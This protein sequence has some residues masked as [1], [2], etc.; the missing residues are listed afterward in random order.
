[1]FEPA[2][3]E[4]T[5]HAQAAQ[6]SVPTQTPTAT[7]TP[8]ESPPTPTATST[9]THTPF[10]TPT[11]RPTTTVTPTP[12]EK[13][14]S[15]PT[16]RPHPTT[17]LRYV[18]LIQG[19]TSKGVGN[20]ESP[21][22]ADHIIRWREAIQIELGIEANRVLA[23]SY[24]NQ[25]CN[26]EKYRLPMYTALDTCDGIRDAV[27]A[28]DELIEET[29]V[30]EDGQA[31]F[32][33]IGH[34]LGG[35]VAA[36]WVTRGARTLPYVDSVITLDAPLG[37]VPDAGLVGGFLFPRCLDESGL[38]HETTLSI[39]DADLGLE[40]YVRAVEIPQLTTDQA[41]FANLYCTEFYLYEGRACLGAPELDVPVTMGGSW[42][43]R[44][45]QGDL[46]NGQKLDHVTLIFH[47]GT[48]AEITDIFNFDYS[49]I[50]FES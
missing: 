8:T 26:G 14:T 4:P 46:D 42:R 27:A 37:E 38:W 22:Q 30:L 35:F 15:T 13:P 10:P 29:L 3:A 9:P 17:D 50:Q 19:L 48:L 21:S 34:S 32:H 49:Q 6:G 2:P 31:R 36:Y 18:V 5:P 45:I 43:T 33:I 25:Y 41:Y 28:L 16:I 1:M 20:C 11:L 23:L 7:A 39:L 47:Q 12:T 40:S 24:T 44:V